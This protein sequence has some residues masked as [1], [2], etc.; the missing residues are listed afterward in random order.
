MRDEA[1]Q[2]VTGE[3]AALFVLQSHWRCGIG[4]LLCEK[5]LAE[6]RTRGFSE[7]AL[8]VLEANESARCFYNSLGFRPDG[9]ARVFLE[10]SNASFLELRYRRNMALAAA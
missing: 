2:G 8:W 4:R 6:A 7:V 9:G 5:M 3:I 10:R 1:A